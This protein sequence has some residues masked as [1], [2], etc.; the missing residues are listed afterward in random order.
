MDGSVPDEGQAG[1]PG[2]GGELPDQGA[3]RHVA[4]I[5]DGNGRWAESQGL[6][7]MKGHEHGVEAA[8]RVIE[9]AGDLGIEILTLFAFSVDNWKR[10]AEEV[11]FLMDLLVSFVA[12]KRSDLVEQKIGFRVI[13]DTNGLPD[14]ARQ[15]VLRTVEATSGFTERLVVLAICYGAQEEIAQAARRIAVDAVEGRLSPEQVDVEL[16]SRYLYT[17]DLTEPDLF[18]RTAGETRLSNFLLWQLRYTELYFAD[19][20]WPDFGKKHLEQAVAEFCRRRRTFGGLA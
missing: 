17:A 2:D 3:P 14:E 1:S 5:M 16:F 15:E 13:G 7:R 6:P 12:K 19:V 9:A 11:G 20:C 10:P 8:E 4:I 18:I